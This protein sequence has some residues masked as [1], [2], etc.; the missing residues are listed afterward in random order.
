[1]FGM[2]YENFSLLITKDFIKIDSDVDGYEVMNSW[3]HP[4]M[5]RHA[6]LACQFGGDILEI[7]FGMGIS[8]NYIQSNS[9]KSHTIVEIHPQIIEELNKWSIDKPNVRIIEGDWV[10]KLD[11]ICSMKYDGIFFDTHMD[12]NKYRLRELIVDKCLKEGGV[13]TWFE[14]TGIDVF[15]YGNIQSEVVEVNPIDCSYYDLPHAIC[16]YYINSK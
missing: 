14:P 10:D 13:F 11:E 3:E 5:K 9:I 2:V 16:P 4:L 15:M 6:D 1:M 7:G 12:R 8:A